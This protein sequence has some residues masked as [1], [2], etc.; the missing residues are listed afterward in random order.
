[1]SPVAPSVRDSVGSGNRQP[2]VAEGVRGSLFSGAFLPK[3]LGSRGTKLG[4]NS[5]GII[6]SLKRGTPLG[7]NSLGVTFSLKRV[8]RLVVIQGGG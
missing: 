7:N 4:S 8:Q 5:G 3:V 6:F 2:T 1:M